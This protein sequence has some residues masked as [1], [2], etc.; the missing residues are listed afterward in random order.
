MPFTECAFSMRLINEWL[1]AEPA[2]LGIQ[3]TGSWVN[4]FITQGFRMN[5]SQLPMRLDIQMIN[6]FDLIFLNELLN[7]KWRTLIEILDLY[8]LSAFCIIYFLPTSWP[9]ITQ[10]LV[11]NLNPEQRQGLPFKSCTCTFPICRG[12]QDKAPFLTRLF[13]GHGISTES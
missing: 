6:Y 5:T 7:L 2:H 11:R 4:L 3:L 9:R 1:I 12:D 10:V 8:W 13:P